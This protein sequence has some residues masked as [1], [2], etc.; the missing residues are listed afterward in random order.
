MNKNYEKE[1]PE[2]YREA[3]TVDAKAKKTVVLM[4]IASVVFTALPLAAVLLIIRPTGFFENYSLARNLIFLA[5]LF[6]YIVLHELVHGLAYKLMT[7]QKLTF[8]LTLTVA[9]CGMPD[10]YTYRRTALISLLAPFTVFSILFIALMLLF[11]DQWDKAYAG[12]LFAV[13]FGGCV[14]DLYDTLLYLTKFRDPRT[15]MRDTGP[16][17]TFYLPGKED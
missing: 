15:L 11:K 6:A 1:L 4:S 14:G 7:K 17:Q 9:Y 12:L 16:K 5:S 8:G 2:G 10:I 3:F 13:H